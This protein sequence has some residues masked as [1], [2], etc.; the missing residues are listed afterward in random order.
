MDKPIKKYHKW[1]KEDTAWLSCNISGEYSNKELA[2]ILGRSI[3]SVK[4]RRKYLKAGIIKPDQSMVTAINVHGVSSYKAWEKH[5]SYWINTTITKGIVY[6]KVPIVDEKD[7]KNVSCNTPYQYSASIIRTQLLI[8]C[9]VVFVWTLI[10]ILLN[11][12]L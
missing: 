3:D 9:L 4:T 8:L 1:S 12:F 11:V 10:F 2:T 7:C 6:N 5:S